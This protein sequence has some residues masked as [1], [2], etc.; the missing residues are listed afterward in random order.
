MHYIIPSHEHVWFMLLWQWDWVV[1]SLI[2]YEW[3][4]LLAQRGTFWI[5]CIRQIKNQNMKLQK[6]L[7]K[8][9][10]ILLPILMLSFSPSVSIK[11]NGPTAKLEQVGNTWFH[12]IE[13][14][15]HRLIFQCVKLLK[16]QW[17]MLISLWG[18]QN[19]PVSPFPVF[20]IESQH[21][22]RPVTSTKW[23]C[24]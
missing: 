20:Q 17:W 15:K 2:K 14:L 22:T 23:I 7:I 4:P 12:S 3:D 21:K 18:L 19:N 5:L 11:W 13:D 1:L 6:Q 9:K 24:F 8:T 10:W 16:H